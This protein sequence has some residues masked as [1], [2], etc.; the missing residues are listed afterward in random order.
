MEQ[1]HGRREFGHSRHVGGKRCLG[2]LLLLAVVAG[3][4]SEPFSF[5]PV[6]GKITYTDNTLIPADQIMVRL[7]PLEPAQNGKDVAP[8][9]TGEVNV[10]DG[11]F[12]GV[13]SHKPLDGVVPGQYRVM[14]IALKSHKPDGV[15][16][17][18]Y[19][20]ATQSPLQIEVTREKHDF[21]DLKVEK[22]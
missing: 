22:P 21:P 11:T 8:A 16:P 2:V 5:V 9:A 1:L 13:T 3:C 15:V 14:V 17:A 19:L 4:N 20:S 7:V 6:T 18:K 12:A 10:K